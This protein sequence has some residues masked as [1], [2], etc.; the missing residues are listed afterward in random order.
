MVIVILNPGI[1]KRKDGKG[2]NLRLSEGGESVLEIGVSKDFGTCHALKA[3][4]ERCADW[5]DI[6][7]TTFC[8]YHIDQGMK[9]ARKGRMEYA[10]GYIHYRY[11]T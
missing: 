4:G 2:F 7:H 3:D 10:V 6:R 8:E 9:R 11:L 5:V 1:M